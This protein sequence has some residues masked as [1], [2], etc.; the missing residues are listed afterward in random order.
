VNALLDTCAFLYWVSDN[1]KLILSQS[2]L[3]GLP[4]LSDD[5]KFASYPVTV[6]WD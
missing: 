5:S 6:I 2:I 4:I 1:P 3:L